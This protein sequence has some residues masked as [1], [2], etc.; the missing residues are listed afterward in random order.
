MA[1]NPNELILDR[2]R[3][4]VW[5]DLTTGQMLFRL[6]SLENPTLQCTAEGEEVTDAVGAVITTL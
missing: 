3:S 5:N 2:V 1:F 4:L 6:T